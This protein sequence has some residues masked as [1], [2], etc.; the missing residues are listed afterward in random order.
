[1]NRPHA[2]AAALFRHFAEVFK[3]KRQLHWSRGLKKRYAIGEKNDEDTRS[4]YGGIS[5]NFSR[6]L[7][8]NGWEKSG[9][10]LEYIQLP[11]TVLKASHDLD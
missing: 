11:Y 7:K 6:L 9:K 4:F 8:E 1:M 10:V 3:G 5:F 2:Q